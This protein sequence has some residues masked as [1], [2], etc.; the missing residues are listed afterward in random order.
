MALITNKNRIVKDTIVKINQKDYAIT[1]DT[2]IYQGAILTINTA[3]KVHNCVANEVFVGIAQDF[4]SNV[5]GNHKTKD[6]VTV[7]YGQIEFFSYASAGV[8]DVGKSAYSTS[9]DTIT[10][11]ANGTY[12]GVIIDVIV[13][14]GYWIKVEVIER[15]LYKGLH[16]TNTDLTTSG[17]P[18]TI[19]TYDGT[20]TQLS[21]SNV[22]NAIDEY[23]TETDF[24][25]LRDRWF[26]QSITWAC[27]TYRDYTVAVS[28]DE[29]TATP[30]YIPSYQEIEALGCEITGIDADGRGRMGLYSMGTNGYPDKL[31][32]E[33][34]R[35]DLSSLGDIELYFSSPLKIDRGWYWISLA[36]TGDSTGAMFRSISNGENLGLL[37][38]DRIRDTAKFLFVFA[39]TSG[40]SDAMPNPFPSCRPIQGE[41]PRMFFRT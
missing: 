23:I 9:N 32:Y 27:D 14:S 10:L 15:H 29:I 17:H 2:T 5:V 28:A 16:S 6:V 7:N 20:L 25:M 39:E 37:G 19:I 26:D 12:I 4:V 40:I 22:Q 18:A 35:F 38:F 24:L 1:S 34:D 3:G 31:L 33:T 30:I 41:C 13:G 8:S 36:Y 11:T 21:A